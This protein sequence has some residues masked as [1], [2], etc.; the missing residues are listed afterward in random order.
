MLTILCDGS[1]CTDRAT[2]FKELLNGILEDSGAGVALVSLGV[3]GAAVRAGALD[4]AI[5]QGQCAIGAVEV[6]RVLAADE[7]VVVNL[8]EDLKGQVRMNWVAGAPEVI[9][10]NLKPFVDAPV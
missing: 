7:V 1:G 6:V 4:V 10:L 8:G 5:G 2:R 9:E 3:G